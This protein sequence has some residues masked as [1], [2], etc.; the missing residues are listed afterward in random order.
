MPKFS[1]IS[2][3]HATVGVSLTWSV[4]HVLGDRFQWRTHF[5]D[6]GFDSGHI[7]IGR[8]ALVLEGQQ[9]FDQRR[10]TRRSL[11]VADIALEQSYGKWIGS[12]CVRTVGVVY[13]SC[14]LWIT[15]LFP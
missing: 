11:R 10:Q 14:F 7:E 2:C 1:L 9:H 3:S 13:G 5:G 8:N 6:L 12:V 4:G 15:N